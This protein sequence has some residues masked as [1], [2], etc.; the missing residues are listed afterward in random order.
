MKQLFGF[1]ICLLLIQEGFAQGSGTIAGKVLNESS[2]QAL[3]GV[4]IS[5]AGTERAAATDMDGRFSFYIAP[6]TYTIR[7]ASIG[8]AAKS[9][10]DVIVKDGT[11]TEL[12][13]A[14]QTAATEMTGIVITTSARKET[15]SSVLAIQ[16]ANAS[17]SDGISMEAIRKS[18]DRNIG[19]VLKRVSGTSIQDNK[20]V[21]VRGLSDRYN[22]SMING[23]ILPSTEPDRRT[24]SFDVIPSH[25]IDHILINKTASPDMPGDFSG[26][27]VQIL[28]KDI[29]F[30]SFLS[31]TVGGSYNSLS[32]GKAFDIGMLHPSDYFGF[33]NGTR[34]LPAKF[35]GRKRYLS[36]NADASPE[37]RLAASRLLRNNYGSRYNGNA[38]P[39]FNFQL[40]WGGRK[41][42]KNDGTL[43]AVV[44]LTYRNSQNIQPSV[45]RDYQSLGRDDYAYDYA[46]TTYSFTTNIG[47]MANVA[48]KKGR[49]KI[50][51][52]NLANRLLDINN[53]Q[54]E[55][56]N[57]NNI[58]YIRTNGS[59]T[60]VRSLVSSQLEGDHLLQKGKRLKW[61]LNYAFT[62]QDQPDYRVLPYAV[63]L[64][65]MG[66][67]EVPFRVV[68]RD[69]YRF[70]SELKDHAV[71][72]NLNYTLPLQFGNQKQLLKAGLLTQYKLRDFSTRIF[73]YE[74]ATA[75][76]NLNLTALPTRQVFNDG[77]IYEEG[78]VLNEIT[79]NAD[80]YDA[81]M[82]LY[83]AYAMI[84]GRISEKLR[85]VY[86]LR[87]ER[88][89]FDVNTAS[90]SDPDININKNY[91]DFLPSINLT[92]NLTTNSNL[93]LSASRTVSRPEFRELANFTFYD[94]I[95][96][97][98]IQGNTDLKRSQNTNLDLRYEIYPASG[99]VL[100]ASVF[101]KHF[102]NPIEQAVVAG[103]PIDA[104]RFTF[105]NPDLA[106]SYGIEL[107][108]RKKMGFLGAAPWLNNL[109]FNLNGAYINSEVRFS[110]GDNF[111]D[112]NR[113][114]QGQSP[115]LVNAGL[116]YA[117]DNN[118][119]S[120]S[121]L[122]NRIGERIAYVG[123]QDYPD[124]YENGRTMLDFQ[125]A[126]KVLKN[127]G[128]L[129]LNLSDLLNQRSVFYQNVDHRNAYK[130]SEDKIQW[131]SLYGRTISLSFSYNIR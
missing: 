64:S 48:W 39:G 118:Q 113:P 69:T 3:K 15:V 53:L 29:P 75:V 60:S 4:T 109:S 1:L 43:G 26:G 31:I 25:L 129:K 19:E 34:A 120:F 108:L 20:F 100:S 10:A 105:N 36:Y 22:V 103:S 37:R 63:N 93:R 67:K 80:A 54:R 102:K 17:I 2:G 62:S 123:S 11:V 47:L 91:T 13:I 42:L 96:N 7:V 68:L 114:M 35:P 79:N 71:G 38:L 61:N 104:L 27:I 59:L 122:V 44:A 85:A 97:V 30:R 8:F 12:P 95:R 81:T 119:L 24:F 76:L 28:T 23:A 33:D 127:E 78:F 111:W 94:F 55:G 88:F 72:A 125:A 99:E 124:I 116:Q 77:N 45:R 128:E 126:L 115:W 82:G 16:R 74:A 52:K 117:T 90:F 9:I 50:V 5:I 86:G 65:E 46:D 14:L 112:K 6:G 83:A 21:I 57:Y 41:E 84:D 51:L 106:R 87:V 130:A 131:S 58:Q 101:Y 121:A 92:Y 18:P 32:T 89:G 56:S 110:D 49:S 98:Q 107:E 73:R 70:W 66:N 40:N